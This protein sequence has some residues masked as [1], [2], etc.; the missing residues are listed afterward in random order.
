MSATGPKSKLKSLLKAFSDGNTSRNS[1]K[2]D[3][4]KL[5]QLSQF[6]EYL[7]QLKSEDILSISAELEDALLSTIIP[8]SQVSNLVYRDLMS[9]I[10]ILNFNS[11]LSKLR[12]FYGAL[13]T[14]L[15]NNRSNS[16]RLL[17]G[18]FSRRSRCVS[19]GQCCT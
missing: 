10:C 9:Q 8:H 5:I 6:I 19:I 1:G 12:D 18:V 7:Q 14:L 3:T 4:N 15:Q 17:S 13:Q 2:T 11:N 16:L